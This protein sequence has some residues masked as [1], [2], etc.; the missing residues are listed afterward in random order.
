MSHPGHGDPHR[1]TLRLTAI[2]STVAFVAF[3]LWWLV[4]GGAG[5]NR[6]MLRSADWLLQGALDPVVSDTWPLGEPEIAGGVI[7]VLAAVLA[8]RRRYRAAALIAGGF[9][10]MSAVQLATIL[11]LADIHH[12]KLDVDALSHIY[13]SGHAARV[14]FVGTSLAV[15]SSRR[16][17]HWVLA[18]AAVLALMV[19]VDRTDSR[20]QAGSVVVGG[21]LLGIAASAWFAFAYW[22]LGRTVAPTA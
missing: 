5:L 2:A 20:I 6:L 16:T 19:A 11:V 3:T 17:R 13:P 4:D 8:W 12:V 1:Q 22:G 21:L 7:V 9:L 10:L 14:P 15:L 18:G